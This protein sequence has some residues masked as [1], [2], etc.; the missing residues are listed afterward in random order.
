MLYRHHETSFAHN[1]PFDCQVVLKFCTEY[2]GEISKWTDKWAIRYD[3]WANDISWHLSLTL[4][5]RGPSYLGLT[6]TISWLLMPWLLRSPGRKG[7]R[8]VSGW[9][10]CVCVCVC[11]WGGGVSYIPCSSFASRRSVFISEFLVSVFDYH[12]STRGKVMR[13]SHDG[14]HIHHTCPGRVRELLVQCFAFKV[15]H[16]WWPGGLQ[17][18]KPR[19]NKETLLISEYK[20]MQQDTSIC[21]LTS[22]IMII[23]WYRSLH[24]R[25]SKIV[26]SVIVASSV[27]LAPVMWPGGRQITAESHHV[28]D[29]SI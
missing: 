1:T 29:A 16:I 25:L 9:G 19:I 18:P 15:S 5:V 22:Y 8:L 3:L 2:D 26:S 11:M 24:N 6:R 10:W 27:L 23:W 4:N 21:H 20:L 12:R 7:L 13:K 14:T 17:S 28:I